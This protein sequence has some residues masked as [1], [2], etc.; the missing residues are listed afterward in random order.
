ML[1]L[2]ALLD[3]PL[4]K[5]QDELKTKEQRHHPLAV[6]GQDKNAMRVLCCNESAKQSA[7]EPL[8]SLSTALALCP[9]LLT[10]QQ[11]PEREKTT[12]QQLALIAYS[13]SPAVII[14]EQGL[15]LELSGC[16]KL[17]HSYRQ[18]LQQLQKN[19]SLRCSQI[20]MGIADSADAARL[21]CQPGFRCELPESAEVKQQ[22]RLTPLSRLRVQ[23]RQQQSFNQ[24]GLT[25]LGDLL[26]LPR[27]ELASRFGTGIVDQLQLLL[28]E[29]PCQLTRFKPPVTFHDL[30]QSPQGIFSKQ[31][32]LFPMKTL[33][34]RLSIYLQ[35]RQCYCRKIE[36]RF[37]PLIGEPSSMCV[38][39]SGSQ[40]SWT[41]LLDL[42]RLQ[43]E[44]I[45]LPASIETII[46]SSDDFVDGLPEGLDL[47]GTAPSS[48]KTSAGDT[49]IEARRLIDSLRARLGP[50]AL[51][52]PALGGNY[53]PEEAGKVVALGEH[54]QLAVDHN[55]L[56]P[57]WLLPKPIAIQLRN[58][59][60]FWRQP[61]Y[62][63]SGPQRLSDNWWQSDR[64]R[65]YYLA[66]DNEGSRYWLFK[67]AGTDRWF[68]QGIFS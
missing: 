7:V 5:Q 22:L 43:L 67:Q 26:A 66:C 64:Q 24:L 49:S 42:S 41:T 11:Q 56:Q 21:L 8:L 37:E 54:Q 3:C 40:N 45:D 2:D 68:V 34:Q 20:D 9:D 52:Q 60:L 50:E 32:L 28:G 62:V 55:G 30:L 23:R 38:T 35:A 10:L 17:F 31:G 19:L 39:L 44:R 51:Q 65:D 1:P 14:A 12:L 13:F 15:W 53:L 29:K 63:L 4:N 16:E 61:L 36:W 47:F 25:R 57:L 46:L 27:A 48:D 33:L 58:Q 6:V 18:L 59:Q